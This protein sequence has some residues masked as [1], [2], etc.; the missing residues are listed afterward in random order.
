M[1]KVYLLKHYPEHDRLSAVAE[2][3]QEIGEFVEWLQIH[4]VHLMSWRALRDYRSCIRCDD[5]TRMS[6]RPCTYCEGTGR[7]PIER[8]QW[9]QDSRSITQLLADYFAIDLDQIEV[10]KR[11]MLDALRRPRR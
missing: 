8:E 11:A 1:S 4:G 5:G 7:V 6:G 3:S 2:R 10:E 9:V